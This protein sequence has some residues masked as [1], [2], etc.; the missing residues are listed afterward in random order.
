MF[1]I[2]E[3]CWFFFILKLFAKISEMGFLRR[4]KTQKGRSYYSRNSKYLAQLTK[5]TAHFY[6]QFYPKLY[7]KI[8]SRGD[9]F[10]NGQ[11]W[12]PN[13]REICYFRLSFPT[14]LFQA[15]RLLA[16]YLLQTCWGRTQSWQERSWLSGRPPGRGRSWRRGLT[17]SSGRTKEN[18]TQGGHRGEGDHGGE[19]Q[20]LPR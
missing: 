2:M 3:K 9:N 4:E 1:K 5:K 7:L 20:Q 15:K 17:A 13:P 16:I 10:L 14:A 12:Q 18:G 6:S 8:M 11:V 19:V